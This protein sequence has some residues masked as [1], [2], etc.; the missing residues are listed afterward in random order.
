MHAGPLDTLPEPAEPYDAAVLVNVLE[1]ID[2][3][4]GALRRLHAMLRPGGALLVFVP[5]NAWL[6]GSLD[7][8]VGHVR[9]YGREEL[10][11]VVDRAGFAI[12]TLRWVDAGGVAPWYFVGRVL[13]RRKFDPAVGRLYDRAVVPL[14]R[15]VEGAVAPPIGKNL[16]CIARRGA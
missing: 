9:R 4:L 11:T 2:D 14:L 8:L 15:V 3:D 16:L 1:H 12:D 7:A 10:R 5:A 6:Y 13:R